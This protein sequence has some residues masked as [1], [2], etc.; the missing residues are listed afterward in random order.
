MSS[1]VLACGLGDARVLAG[2]GLRGRSRLVRHLRRMCFAL[3]I[4]TGS[5]FLGQAQ[6]IPKPV[7][8][9]P[10]LWILALLPLAVMRYWL[11]RVRVRR[12]PVSRRVATPLGFGTLVGGIS[13][14]RPAPAEVPA[15]RLH[16]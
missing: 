1:I 7:R 11:W 4:A 8:I 9:Y 15:P 6:V 16:Q 10:V 3:C 13:G 2:G 5:F 14:V 12:G